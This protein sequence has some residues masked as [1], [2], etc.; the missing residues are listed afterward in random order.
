MELWASQ[1]EYTDEFPLDAFRG[2][3]EQE[4]RTRKYIYTLEV[5][6]IEHRAS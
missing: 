4:I 6:G 5:R 2:K 3:L 1:Q